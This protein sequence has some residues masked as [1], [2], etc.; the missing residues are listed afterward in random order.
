MIHLLVSA[1]ASII[2]VILVGMFDLDAWTWWERTNRR[3]IAEGQL[4]AARTAWALWIILFT[5]AELIIFL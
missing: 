4:S 5:L 2:S 1:L 3:H